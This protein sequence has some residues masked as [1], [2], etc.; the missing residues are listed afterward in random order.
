MHWLQPH[1]EVDCKHQPVSFLVTL[2]Q[3]YDP[4][5]RA[6]NVVKLEASDLQNLLITPRSPRRS[7]AIRAPGTSGMWL[8]VADRRLSG[9]TTKLLTNANPPVTVNAGAHD[10]CRSVH[11]HGTPIRPLKV[12]S[13]CS[14]CKSVAMRRAS[15]SRGE[16]DTRSCAHDAYAAADT[17]DKIEHYFFQPLNITRKLLL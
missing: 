1:H 8:A 6:S 10:H 3:F 17:V 12:T 4:P 2:P 9:D 14:C 7:E 15:Y 11:I 16:I 5:P 13:R